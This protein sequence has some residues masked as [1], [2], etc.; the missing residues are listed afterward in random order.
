M[1]NHQA[2]ARAHRK[3]Q[4]HP[5]LARFVLLPGT[6]DARLMS[7]CRPEDP[8]HRPGRRWDPAKGGAVGDT[9]FPDTDLKVF[10]GESHKEQ[11]RQPD[12]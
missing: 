10:T 8:G 2:I 5:V 1:K 12:G 4:R 11:E 6:L 7:D 9:C 3:G